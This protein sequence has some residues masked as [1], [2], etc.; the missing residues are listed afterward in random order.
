LCP[1][2]TLDLTVRELVA[3]GKGRAEADAQ[4]WRRALWAAWYAA[5]FTR[6]K[7]LPRLAP[8]LRNIGRR[9]I[10]KKSTDQL[11]RVVEHLNALFGGAD[12][13]NKKGR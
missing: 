1:A 9:R 8:M 13:R 11:L 2:E 12:H 6:A 4:S 10:V 5:N 3:Y 7:R